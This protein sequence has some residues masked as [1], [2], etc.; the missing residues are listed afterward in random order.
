[1]PLVTPTRAEI[2]ERIKTDFR[3]E[4]GADPL[5]RSVEYGLARALMGQSAALYGYARYIF[6]QLFPDTADEQYFW[7]WAGIF[8]GDNPQKPA[9]FWRG[10][11][12][13]T[14]AVEPIPAGTVITRSDGAEYT[15]DADAVVGGG[16]T[17]T[18]ACTASVAGAAGDVDVGQ[19][20][21]LGTPIAGV[22]T[23]C[24]VSAVSQT[25]EDPET[26]A[27]GLIRLLLRLSSPPKGGGPGD[28]VAW[29]LAF[30]GCTRAWEFP[31]LDGPNNVAVAF[32]RDGDGVGAFAIPD[33]TERSEMLAYL[34]T[35]VPVTVVV[36]VIDL[37][38]EVVDIMITDLNP[39]TS[40]VRDAIET[41]LQDLF[42]RAAAPDSSLAISQISAAISSA[43]GEI[44]HTL[45]A[46]TIA[47][48][49]A[50]NQLLVLGT[51]TYV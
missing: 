43:A 2:L 39:D 37:T 44:S 7:R 49:A 33:P 20:L 47:P 26:P 23:A 28:Y 38:A 36:S 17:V 31:L 35:V 13:F 16:G 5:R 50:T 10:S 18:I 24:V 42:T 14:G 45:T 30:P 8:L 32:V 4:V 22:D 6:K 41:S 11:V 40:D 29:A 25:G 19:P 51:I 1:M 46:P 3:V 27:D 21:A 34:E 9:E 48:V 12:D 15:T